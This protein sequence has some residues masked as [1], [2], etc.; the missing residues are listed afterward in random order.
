MLAYIEDQFLHELLMIENEDFFL[1]HV[2]GPEFSFIGKNVLITL[3]PS[4]QTNEAAFRM[5]IFIYFPFDTN[6]RLII[7]HGNLLDSNKRGENT[8]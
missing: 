4:Q 3:S 6:M 5:Q 8:P 1:T 7:A 2:W